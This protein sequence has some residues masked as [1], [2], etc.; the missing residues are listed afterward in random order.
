MA[1]NEYIIPNE[2]I[3][4]YQGEITSL[5]DLSSL[6]FNN[7]AWQLSTRVLQKEEVA[8]YDMDF[9]GSKLPGDLNN[10][11]V[12]F[13]TPV[14][15]T[16]V[17]LCFLQTK[18][19]FSESQD[20]KIELGRNPEDLDIN[21]GFVYDLNADEVGKIKNCKCIRIELEA[22]SSQNQL[23]CMIQK[24]EFTGYKFQ[25]FS[26]IDFS[27]LPINSSIH[28]YASLNVDIENTG[29]RY[30]NPE[31]ALKNSYCLSKGQII[32]YENNSYIWNGEKWI[33]LGE[34]NT[35]TQ[36]LINELIGSALPALENNTRNQ[37][38]MLM[39]EYVDF[40]TYYAPKTDIKLIDQSTNQIYKLFIDNGEL[41]IQPQGGNN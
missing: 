28:S 30:V 18:G 26:T 12:K 39:S 3:C 7:K 4:R 15:G 24:I 19:Q 1:I 2:A 25:T 35:I 29:I 13:Q 21:D 17:Y 22:T 31:A 9:D 27:T 33:Q 10:L 5:E 20:V 6:N 16:N 41:Q 38:S 23:K 11:K 37:V 8:W 14:A 32:T 40:Q 34:N 36:A